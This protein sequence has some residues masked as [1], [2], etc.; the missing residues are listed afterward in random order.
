MDAPD[1]TRTSQFNSIGATGAGGKPLP[2]PILKTIAGLHAAKYLFVG[3][4][5]GVFEA[6][7]GGPL[8]LDALAEKV[9]AP[10]RTLRIVTD[11]LV[12]Q[13]MLTC[14]PGHGYRNSPVAA[15]FLSGAPGEDLRPILQMWDGVVY[16]QW[17]HLEDSIRR[18]RRTYGYFDFTLDEQHLFSA[19]V[20]AL[21]AGSARALAEQY[22][23][24]AHRSLLDLGGGSGSF[25]LAAREKYPALEVSMFELP[26]TTASLR[27]A[28]ASTP[29]GDAV[30]IV[31]GNFFSDPIPPGHD[32]FLLANV[33]HLHLPEKN[34]ELLKHIRAAVEPGA[35]VLLVDFWTNPQRTEPAF[36]CMLAGQFQIVSGEG[37]VYSVDACCD[38]LREAGFKP[39]EHKPFGGAASLIVGEAT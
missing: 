3:S 14:E 20:A 24:S 27:Q 23:F 11:A 39:V 37:D 25:V 33:A 13:G 9:G 7:A 30:K 31:E 21:T 28:L 18:D 17:S 1:S 10:P 4:K 36:A 29:G 2:E 12:A 19:G 15:A 16:K 35:R 8:M 34:I 22:D 5:L 38:W 32:V 26:K 6:L